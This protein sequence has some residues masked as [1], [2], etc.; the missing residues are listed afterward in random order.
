[1]GYPIAVMVLSVT[2]LWLLLTLASRDNLDLQRARQAETQVRTLQT[3]VAYVVGF[4]TPIPLR[5]P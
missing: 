4:P 2:C 5:K 3:Q 1:M